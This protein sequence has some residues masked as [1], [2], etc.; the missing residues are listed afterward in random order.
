MKQ[1]CEKEQGCFIKNNSNGY[2]YRFYGGYGCYT[3][4]T[5][6]FFA[7]NPKKTATPGATNIYAWGYKQLRLGLQ[8]ATP[9]AAV[10]FDRVIVFGNT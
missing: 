1:L 6:I 7:E 8:T 5:L 4:V 3:S 10:F 9:G 2:A